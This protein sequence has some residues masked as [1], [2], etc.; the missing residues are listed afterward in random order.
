MMKEAGLLMEGAVKQAGVGRE[1]IRYYERVGLLQ[2]P[3]RT[4]SRYRVYSPEAVAR[5][6]FDQS[7]N[8]TQIFE[9]ERT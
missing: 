7:R 4:H 1:T 5:V 9:K 2:K 3:M 8:E 6:E